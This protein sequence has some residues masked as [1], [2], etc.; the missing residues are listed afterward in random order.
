MASWLARV[1]K[2][3][4]LAVLVDDAHLADGAS[5]ALLA[6]LALS[7]TELPLLLLA[8]TVP[9]AETENPQALEVLRRECA[10][11]ELTPLTHEDTDALVASLFGDVPHAALVADRLHKATRGNPRE[12]LDL[13]QSLVTRAVIRY[14]DGH[15]LLPETLQAQDLPSSAAEACART[16]ASLSEHAR[17]LA[18][19]HALACH[20]NLSRRDYATAAPELASDRLDAAITELVAQR[21]LFG[22]SGA[23]ALARHE[24]AKA[25]LQPLEPAG[26]RER[27]GR[28]ARIYQQAPEHRLEHTHHLLEAGEEGPAVDQLIPLIFE[29]GGDGLRLAVLSEL[30]PQ[31]VAAI[32]A[33]GLACAERLGRAPRDVHELR[34]GLVALSVAAD[35]SHYE[36]TAPAWLAQLEHDSGLALYREMA[37]EVP[38]TERL[39]TAMER[40]NARYAATPE[41]ERVL[42]PTQAIQ[43]L[44]HYAAISMAIGSRMQDAALIASLPAV[45][46]PFAGLSPVVNAIWQNAIGTREAM[47]DNQPERARE[48]WQRG[49][50]ALSKVS[51]DELSY[52]ASIRGALVYGIA[53]VEARLGIASA[54]QN[55]RLLEDVP[56]QAVSAMSLRKV[57]RLNLGDFAGAERFRRRAE[58]IAMNT[59][60]RPRFSSMLQTELI[61]YA[62]AGDLIGIRQVARG[63]EPLAARFPGWMGFKHLADGYYE[64]VRDQH[65]KALAA[66]E[67]GLVV[68]APIPRTNG[69]SCGAWPR[70]VAGA[71]EALVSM[72][73]AEQAQQ[74]AQAA[75]ESCARHNIVTMAFPIQRALALAAAELGDYDGAKRQLEQVL[76]CLQQHGV[77]GLELG[78]SY[79]AR[80]RVAIRFGDSQAVKT[81]LEL[82]A[83]QYRYGEGSSLGAR[84]ER[85][86]DAAR[87]T[88][89]S[90]LPELVDFRTRIASAE[91]GQVRETTAQQALGSARDAKERA[92]RALQLLCEAQATDAGHLY[93]YTETGL[94]CMA[95]LGERPANPALDTAATDALESATHAEVTSTM[96]GT[97][98]G[99]DV[100]QVPDDQTPLYTPVH[101][102]CDVEGKLAYAGTLML[103]DPPAMSVSTHR[104]IKAIARFLVNE[105]DATPR[106]LSSA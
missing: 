27:H 3:Q 17:T 16:V 29:A 22:D 80:V 83:Q 65:E 79:E 68:S 86:L 49:L 75:L 50:D 25:L 66:F 60:I 14:R 43:G 24:W 51:K 102:C 20:R 92:E 67:R 7:M 32:L 46:E 87:S 19:V 70:L 56:M 90:S 95:S 82:A 84:Y 73:K 21:V 37:P 39:R 71:V 63:I 48:R 94:R 58:R 36:R 26:L 78:A 8:T 85:L 42:D 33:R 44:A 10:S 89:A 18:Q 35:E 6:S 9:D 38:A 59:N 100:S 52:V 99:S 2:S 88:G 74:R 34:R 77:S 53:S 64:Q 62:L 104:L 13:V 11:L 106:W 23:Y 93:L 28:A 47:C 69:L 76:Q 55:V 30:T 40:A 103:V 101:L 97:M 98:V 72:G 54:E 96:T 5:L 12:T 4:T 41:N 61:A 1:A 57:A 45:L 31:Q 15:W 81:F 91:T 105:G